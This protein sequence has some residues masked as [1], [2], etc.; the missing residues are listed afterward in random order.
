MPAEE[1]GHHVETDQE[2]GMMIEYRGKYNL[3][4]ES[5]CFLAHLVDLKDS[6][7]HGRKLLT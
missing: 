6:R 5:F 2:L 7:I 3:N 4:K 1:I